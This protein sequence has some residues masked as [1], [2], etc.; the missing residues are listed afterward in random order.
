MNLALQ[1]E[2]FVKVPLDP[3][4]AVDVLHGYDRA[5]PMIVSFFQI[6]QSKRNSLAADS[7]RPSPYERTVL[8]EER[9]RPHGLATSNGH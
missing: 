2:A 3:A 9:V 4:I 7:R 5:T 8:E 6:A 1:H